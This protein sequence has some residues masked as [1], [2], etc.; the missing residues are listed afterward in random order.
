MPCATHTVSPKASSHSS[1]LSSSISSSLSSSLNCS[2]NGSLSACLLTSQL[3]SQLTSLGGVRSP[4]SY[5]SR[6]L[7]LN[8]IENSTSCNETDNNTT[9]SNSDDDSDSCKA[10]TTPPTSTRADGSTSNKVFTSAYNDPSAASN[11]LPLSSSK[12]YGVHQT[13]SP[14]GNMRG[15]EER[16]EARI[17]G[18]YGIN[19]SSSN[20]NVNAMISNSINSGNINGNNEKQPHLRLAFPGTLDRDSRSYPSYQ[21]LPYSGVSGVTVAISPRDYNIPLPL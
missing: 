17:N 8:T 15:L 12:F 2:L 1:S 4:S 10:S 21:S 3:S 13:V 19:G 16:L 6:S 9:N 18:I 20:S 5:I 11:S 14:G 7:S